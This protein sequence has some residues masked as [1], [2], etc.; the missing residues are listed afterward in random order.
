MSLSQPIESIK[1]IMRKDDG[2][3]GNAVKNSN[4]SGDLHE[5]PDLLLKR[6]TPLEVHALLDQLKGVLT[7]C[8]EVNHGS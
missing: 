6:F 2:V 5:G 3:V 7:G 4:T 1:D 8:L